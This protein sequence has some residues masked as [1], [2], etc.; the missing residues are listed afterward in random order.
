MVESHRKVFRFILEEF[1]FDS[2]SE[3]LKENTLKARSRII[4]SQIKKEV[5]ARDSGKC[6]ICGAKDEL[7]F[8]HDLP[9]SK[10]GASITA[11]NVRILCA[12][13]NLSKSDKIE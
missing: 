3:N 13:H 12:R 7:H 2:Q 6:V 9:Y 4:P 5:W 11:E 10:G 1:D 8:D